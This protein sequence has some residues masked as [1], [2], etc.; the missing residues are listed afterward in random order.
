MARLVCARQ[1][2]LA[3]AAGAQRLHADR[4]RDV[5]GAQ[6]FAR[7]RLRAC[8]GRDVPDPGRAGPRRNC[9]ERGERH[10]GMLPAVD[11][12]QHRR[13]VMATSEKAPKVVA[14]AA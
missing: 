6:H 7:C 10:R 2:R 8:G 11:D 4:G 12:L 5:S 9:R 14:L 3:G 1:L 13:E